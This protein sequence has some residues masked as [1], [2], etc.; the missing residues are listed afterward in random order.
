MVNKKTTPIKRR[1]TKGRSPKL[2]FVTGGVVSSLG[3]G[4]TSAS[5]GCLL[6]SRGLKITMQKIDP[7]LN[8]DA[9]TMNPFQH[10]EVYVTQDGAETDLDLGHYERYTRATLSANNNLTTGKIY[11]GVIAKERRGDF[12]GKTVQVVPHITDEIKE[13]ILQ[14]TR[15]N[16]A[17]VSIVEIGGTIGDIEGLPFQEAI[18]QLRLQLGRE[19]TMFIHLTLVPHITGAD[20]P[21]TKPT[22]HS[23]G[24]LR[25]IGIQPD[26]LV[27]RTER[28][29]DRDVIAKIA[30]FCSVNAE[31]VIQARDVPTVYEVP[32][33]FREQKL[34]D[35]IISHFGL[36]A[37]AP[38]LAKWTNMVHRIKKP[39]KEVN[40]AIVG[41][42]IHLKDAYKS[43]QEAFVH[44]GAHHNARL[45]IKWIDSERISKEG[46][47][48]LAGLNGILI[49]GGF[50]D[51]GI[52]GKI[53]AIRFAREKRV[54]L[55]GICLGMQ[56]AVIEFARNVL[57]LRK[58]HSSEFDASSP[59]PV[60]DLMHDQKSI[61]DM[62]G[63]M[64]LGSYPCR[65]SAGSLAR[66]A[67]NREVI[68]ER[69]RHR[70]EFNNIY[71]ER[72]I[73]AGLSFSGL[74]PDGK[75]VEMVE[76]PGHPWFVACQFHPEFQS[77]PM[78]PH[79]LFRDFVRAALRQRES[80]AGKTG[81]RNTA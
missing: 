36:H 41:K 78:E 43:I 55:F 21:K 7:Y 71:R 76:L 5:I 9:G 56:C 12:L 61:K 25:R 45:N 64:R 81:N 10:G 3:K 74:S 16:P 69:H 32:L 6:E 20:E 73:R 22:Q 8:V 1:L 70:Y 23:V 35:L 50:G 42:Y 60:I 15:D 28:P 46:T 63:T 67:Y 72:F 52:E 27:C 57:G 33:M 29:L 17:D 11:G 39:A 54:P 2:I 47:S 37:H 65:I 58:A 48:L 68:F 18:R 13:R 77:R 40:L 62:G 34:D 75:L 66:Q 4:I 80:G 26:I 79:P 51:R 49:P 31:N 59:H 53:E 38:D 24:E 30:L 14:V 19:H 44:A